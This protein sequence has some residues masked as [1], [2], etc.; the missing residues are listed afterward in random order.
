MFAADGVDIITSPAKA[1]RANA[2]CERLIGTLRRELLDRLLILNQAHLVK[3][4][5]EYRLRYNR[6]RPH[7]SRAQ[8]PP[9][10]QVNPPPIAGLT[11]HPVRRIPIV[12]GLICECVVAVLLGGGP[13]GSAPVTLRDSGL[14]WPLRRALLLTCPWWLPAPAWP[15]SWPD[16]EACPRERDPSQICRFGDRTQAG[17]EV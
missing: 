14:I 1:P 15:T 4:L 16:L 6:H 2:V 12:S 17:A 7:Q 3:V 9:G 8:R 5:E 13:P 11:D 10:I